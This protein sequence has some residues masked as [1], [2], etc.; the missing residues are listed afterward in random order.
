MFYPVD[1]AIQLLS[2]WGLVQK[3]DE[4][5]GGDGSNMGSSQVKAPD[6][7]EWRHLIL[8]LCPS[9]DKEGE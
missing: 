6:R 8:A 4:Q 3:G 5:A 9:L 1:S 2:N 7:V